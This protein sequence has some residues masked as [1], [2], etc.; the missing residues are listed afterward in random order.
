MIGTIGSLVQETSSRLRWLGASL[1]YTLGCVCT[2]ALL[3]L[4]LGALGGVLRAAMHAAL[5]SLA[6]PHAGAAIVVVVALAY[7]A[8]DLGCF[9]L[10]RPILMPAVP[11]R[12]WRRWEPYGAALA[13]GAALGLGVTTRIW[14]GA[15]YALCAWCLVL[16]DPLRGAL[17]MGTYGAA[18]ALTMFPASWGV[19]RHQEDLDGWL[20]GPLFDIAR[21]RRLMAIALIAFATLLLLAVPS[22][23]GHLLP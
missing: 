12:W 3:G 5:P 14:F 2:A 10:P 1:L 6:I 21:A 18:R 22:P 17:V 16:G 13:Y 4:G 15:F 7:A 23:L 9:A 11:L 8:S 19:A 20:C